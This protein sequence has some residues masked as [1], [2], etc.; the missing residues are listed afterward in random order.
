MISMERSYPHLHT[1]PQDLA[2]TFSEFFMDMIIKICTHLDGI[3]D[4]SSMTQD[5]DDKVVSP[6]SLDT[7]TPTTP[8]EVQ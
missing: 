4:A 5:I 3:R 7:L 6:T 1:T 2:N 8:S